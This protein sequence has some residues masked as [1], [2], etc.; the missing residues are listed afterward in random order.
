MNSKDSQQI[1]DFLHQ[2]E[3]LK[4]V[5]RHSWLPSGRRE[6]VAEHTWRMA[7]MAVL[8][9]SYLDKG[10][11]LAKTIK[12]ILVHDLGEIHATDFP[13]FKKQ[14]KNKTEMERKELLKLVK[15]LPDKLSTE[16]L[17]LWE[18]YEKAKTLEALFAKFLDKTEVLLQ[19]N[20]ADLKFLIKKEVPFNLYHG[21][22]FAEHDEFLKLFRNSINVETLQ[23]YKK[24]KINKKLYQKYL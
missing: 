16:I 19:H 10:L 3:K 18:E 15:P 20:E 7:L 17:G 21:K 11:D 5:L 22:E 12:L 8:L 4:T 13:A 6:S 1:L 23:L 24:H 2:T 14:P 9:H